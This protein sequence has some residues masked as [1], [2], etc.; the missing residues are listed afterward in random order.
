[1]VAQPNIN[2]GILDSS[3]IA[4]ARTYDVGSTLDQISNREGKDAETE[5]KQ[6]ETAYNELANPLRLE[7]MG[8]ENNLAKDMNPLKIQS[9]Q[10]DVQEKTLKNAMTESSFIGGVVNHITSEQDPAKQKAL[11]QSWYDSFE[12]KGIPLSKQGFSRDYTEEDQRKMYIAGLQAADD[13]GTKNSQNQPASVKEWQAAKRSDPARYGNV[14]YPEWLD[15]QA[16]RS[17]DK[18]T[19]R[20]DA[21]KEKE[22]TVAW[23]KAA[24]ERGIEAQNTLNN[25]QLMKE[26]RSDVERGALAPAML[27]AQRIGGVFSEEAAKA[28][29]NKEALK[30]LG[31]QQTLVMAQKLKP[32]SDTDIKYSEQA[33]ATLGK[34]EAGARILE[35][36]AGTVATRERQKRD[37]VDA[38]D[39]KHGTITGAEM[40]FDKLTQDIPL[41]VKDKTGALVL[42]PN[43]KTLSD[44]FGDYLEKPIMYKGDE[45]FTAAGGKDY[46][47]SQILKIAEKQVF[48]KTLLMDLNHLPQLVKL[49][50]LNLL[51]LPRPI[52]KFNLL[53]KSLNKVVRIWT[54]LL[55]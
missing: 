5:S 43:A 22:R 31:I 37:F 26:F 27:I 13:L 46:T 18:I 36:M 17:A 7:K 8:Q 54:L 25:I 38:Y 40:Q 19:T 44:K 1:M 12:S 15:Q 24:D 20:I 50:Q 32:T 2:W 48:L 52:I 49:R 9:E 35:E 42:N 30:A 55:V 29:G 21:Q 45:K 51:F 39:K 14:T 6:Q 34:T 28:A 47:Y 23:L 3:G 16:D 41:L 53:L 33:A 4:K 10:Q 11:Y